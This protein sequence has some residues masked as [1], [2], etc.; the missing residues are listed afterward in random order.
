ME[1][2]R[3]QKMMNMVTSEMSVPTEIIGNSLP[4]DI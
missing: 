2:V 3:C 4:S 1:K